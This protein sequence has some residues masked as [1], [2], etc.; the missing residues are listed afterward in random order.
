MHPN[1]LNEILHEPKGA[2]PN[3]RIATGKFLSI[4]WK[5]RI[6]AMAIHC[7][8]SSQ[9][10]C[11]APMSQTNA[12]FPFRSRM[13]NT[14]SIRPGI[15]GTKMR[16]HGIHGSCGCAKPKHNSGANLK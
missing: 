5:P 16:G 11:H 3:N 9:R 4:K 14:N 2:A 13:I 7:N 12:H 15:K 1:E 10:A 6:H 8:K